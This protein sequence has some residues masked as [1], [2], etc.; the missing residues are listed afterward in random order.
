M[1]FFVRLRI[2]ISF[3]SLSIIFITN[4]NTFILVQMALVICLKGKSVQI[5]CCP[6]TVN[7]ESIQNAT[8][9]NLWEGV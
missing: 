6:A 4:N 5:R 2:E 7:G 1:D 3:A 9:I 8:V